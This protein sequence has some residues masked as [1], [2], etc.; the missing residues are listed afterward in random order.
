MQAEKNNENC[1]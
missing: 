1:Y